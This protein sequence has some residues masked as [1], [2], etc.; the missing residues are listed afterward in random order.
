LALQATFHTAVTDVLF[1]EFDQDKS[2]SISFDEYV[3]G[4]IR[5]AKKYEVV[6]PKISVLQSTYALMDTDKSNS[7]SKAELHN[8]VK[9]HL[10]SQPEVVKFVATVIFNSWDTDHSGTITLK[11]L[12]D[13]IVAAAKHFNITPLPNEES[14]NHIFSVG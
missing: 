10:G 3:S 5:I 9:T 8:Y 1:S 13:G 7:V 12:H 6:T 14:I 4:Y 2:G 11:E